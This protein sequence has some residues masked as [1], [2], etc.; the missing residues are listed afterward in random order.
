MREGQSKFQSVLEAVLNSLAGYIVAIYSQEILF[1]M[2]GISLPLSAHLMLGLWFTLISIIRS[3]ILRRV[4]NWWYVR[5]NDKE[6]M[7]MSIKS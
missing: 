1:P 7:E 4:F 6:N 3:L 5:E 2:F